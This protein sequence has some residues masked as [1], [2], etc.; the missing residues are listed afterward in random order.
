MSKLVNEGKVSV[1]IDDIK[2]ELI[3][4]LDLICHVN[5]DKDE[6]IKLTTKIEMKEK[7][8]LGRSPDVSDAFYMR[9]WFDLFLTDVELSDI[10]RVYNPHIDED[11]Y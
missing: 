6:P 8:P 11:I 4:E 3:E 7:L 5:I 1:E 2:K 9:A 10:E